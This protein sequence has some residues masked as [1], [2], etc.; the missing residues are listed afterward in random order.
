MKK[1]LRA[2]ILTMLGIRNGNIASGV[3]A[4]MQRAQCCAVMDAPSQ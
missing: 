2:I 4:G 3:E 1:G